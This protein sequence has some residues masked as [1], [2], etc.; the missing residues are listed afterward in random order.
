MITSALRAAVKEALKVKEPSVSLLKVICSKTTVYSKCA[1]WVIT[2]DSI[3][4]S[5][6]FEDGGKVE[7]VFSETPQTL[8]LYPQVLLLVVAMLRVQRSAQNW[9]ISLRI[10]ARLFE[11]QQQPVLQ[12]KCRK[13]RVT[14]DSAISSLARFGALQRATGWAFQE[15]P[16]RGT[17]PERRKGIAPGIP[18]GKSDQQNQ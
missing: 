15:G 10:L 8:R 14:D 12:R 16:R 5:R 13:F 4:D 18:I 1:I 3:N 11:L 9:L 7:S 17:Q 6:K 2:H